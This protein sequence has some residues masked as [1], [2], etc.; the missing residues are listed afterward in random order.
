ML[1]DY[2]LKFM[3]REL[4]EITE[5]K[6]TMQSNFSIESKTV[7]VSQATKCK[8]TRHHV[9]SKFSIKSGRGGREPT[10]RR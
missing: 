8:A 4:T 6:N 1:G 7:A 10:P 2:F 3:G 9:Q 5:S